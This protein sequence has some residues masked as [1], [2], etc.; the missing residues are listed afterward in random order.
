MGEWEGRSSIDVLLDIQRRLA[1][2][3]AHLG[4]AKPEET[5][6]EPESPPF[7]R[8]AGAMPPP[9][10]LPVQLMPPDFVPAYEPVIERQESFPAPALTPLPLLPAYESPLPPIPAQ[11][12]EL[13]QTIGLKWAGW[14]GAVVVVIG[15]ALGIKFAYDQRWF[16]ILPPV[17]RLL[18]MS[19]GGFALI[20]AGEL[21]FR[22]IHRVAAAC[23]FG[24][25][26]ATLFLVSYAGHGYYRLYEPETAF[27]LMGLTTVVGAAVALRGN[28]LSIAVLAQIGGNLAPLLLQSDRPLLGSFLAYLLALQAVALVLTWRRGDGRWGSLRWISLAT[29]SL[30]VLAML[31]DRPHDA[32][33]TLLAFAL[34]YAALYQAELILSVVRPR[35]RRDEVSEQESAPSLTLSTSITSPLAGGVI[36]SVTVTALLTTGLLI[37]LRNAPDA[38]QG[39]WV[40]GLATAAAAL[41]VALS[42][43]RP[44]AHPAYPLAIGF[45]VQAA[46]LIVVAVPV[47]LS[48]VSVLY[49]WAVLALAFAVLG[50]RLDLRISRWAGVMVWRLALLYLGWWTVAPLTR[51]LGRGSV[52]PVGA[53]A[54]WLHLFGQDLRAYTIL[55]WLLAAVGHVIAWL[56]H[57]EGLRPA[58]PADRKFQ[59]L[60][61][62][63]NGLAGLAFFTASVAG[64][65]PAGATFAILVYAGLLLGADLLNPRLGLVLQSAVVTVLVTLKWIAVDTLAE[66]LA[67][68]WSATARRPVFNAVMGV[69]VLISAT[70]GALYWTRR[71]ALWEFLT[72]RRGSERVDGAPI[73]VAAPALALAAALMTLFAIALTVEI[74]RVVEAAGP[75]ATVWPVWQ[76]KMLAWTILWTLCLA[77]Y[78]GL[79]RRLEPDDSLRPG[80]VRAAEALIVLMCFKFLLIDTLAFRALSRPP[81]L[82]P[83]ANLQVLAAAVVIGGLILTAYLM[84]GRPAPDGRPSPRPGLPAFAG[85][86]AVLVVLWGGTLEIDRAFE[87][88]IAAGPGPFADPRL[89][90]QVAF[91][92]FW[93]IF[94]VAAIV[95]GFR[96]RTA[97]LRYFG[98]GLFAV[99]LAKVVLF[100]MSHVQTGYRVLSF[101]GLGLLLMG[102]SVL[103][104]KLS[105]VLLRPKPDAGMIPDGDDPSTA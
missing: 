5:P 61:W 30:W 64:L 31:A 25:G 45:R 55:A 93:S 75:A 87:R 17:G 58:D 1:R 19:L 52:E 105:P 7:A 35:G 77:A 100:D 36:F 44:A 43:N 57:Q 14:V 99:T 53:H 103:Y 78:L 54:I 18:M 76:L 94:A 86:L 71:D 73:S 37:L 72:S 59:R 22:R 96:F 62:V 68:N 85:F 51:H 67:P 74:D 95:A 90:K 10:P 66:R 21:V 48:G 97:G 65:P 104:G 20:G 102:T 33:A 38:A 89:A 70:M 11:Q 46:A 91:S 34:I 15:A 60:A 63:T 6:V 69:G 98:L 82:T 49:G 50:N 24:A 42:L 56:I 88:L 84:T 26:V 29:T 83:V 81:L 39:A 28:L 32:T 3:E 23:L 92:I 80:W 9:L 4:L 2:V 79:S 13:E 8:R 40:I 41:G 101:L 16:E 12:S 47:A 27:I